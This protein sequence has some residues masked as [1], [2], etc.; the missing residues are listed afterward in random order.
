MIL[1]YICAFASSLRARE[2]TTALCPTPVRP[3]TMDSGGAAKKPEDAAAAAEALNKK[4][5]LY[6]GGA[7]SAPCAGFPPPSRLPSTHST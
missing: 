5:E 6:V 3:S 4:P 2:S 1:Y 7:C